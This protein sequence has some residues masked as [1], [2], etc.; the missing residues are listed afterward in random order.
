MAR[1]RNTTVAGCAFDAKTIEAVWNKSQKI[2]DKNAFIYRCDILGNTLFR[3]SYGKQTIMGWEIDHIKSVSK[4]G[5]DD[6]NNLQ[7]LNSGANAKKGDTYP[8]P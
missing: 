1:K 8:W 4:G 6:M 5:T 3:G 7:I 2:K